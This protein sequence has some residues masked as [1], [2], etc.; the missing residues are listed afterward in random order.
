MGNMDIQAHLNFPKRRLSHILYNA[1]NAADPE[2]LALVRIEKIKSTFDRDDFCRK[3]TGESV[4][5]SRLTAD[6][7][8]T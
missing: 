2:L 8:K 6:G 1:F 4:A 5:T 3:L 7:D